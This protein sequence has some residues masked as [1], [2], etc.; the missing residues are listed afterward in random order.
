MDVPQYVELDIPQTMWV[1][2]LLLLPIAL[3]PF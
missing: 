3:Q 1:L 2:L